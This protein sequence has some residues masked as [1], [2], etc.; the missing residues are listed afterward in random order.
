MPANQIPLMA[1][2]YGAKIIEVNPEPSNF[3]S[4]ITDI[5]LQGKATEVMGKIEELLFPA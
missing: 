1:K 3:T 2:Q 4:E 5:Y